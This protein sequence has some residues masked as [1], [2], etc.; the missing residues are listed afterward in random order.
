MAEL[1][2]ASPTT[3]PL[4]AP[5]RAPLLLSFALR[6]RLEQWAREEHPHEICGLL[7]GRDGP[8]GTTVS[9]ITRGGN[10]SVDRLA[11]LSSTTATKR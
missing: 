3:A 11:E 6:A 8:A 10:L 1:Q 5:G 4:A 9:R 7:V 2:T